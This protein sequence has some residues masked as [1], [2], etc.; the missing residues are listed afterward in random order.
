MRG[1]VLDV[2]DETLLTTWLNVKFDDLDRSIVINACNLQWNREGTFQSAV[3]AEAAA[4]QRGISL[5][6]FPSFGDFFDY[7]Y[8]LTCHKAQGSQ[9]D[10]VLVYPDGR[11]DPNEEDT[12]RWLYTAVTRAKSH[13]IYLL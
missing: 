12:R 4:N 1:I 6:A 13:L 3:D 2:V 11:M 7:G 9:F 8:A 5:P 10:T